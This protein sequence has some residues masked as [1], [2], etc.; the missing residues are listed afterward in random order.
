MIMKRDLRASSQHEQTEAEPVTFKYITRADP[1]WLELDTLRIEPKVIQLQLV[2][3][4][5]S[6]H[7]HISVTVSVCNQPKRCNHT[8]YHICMKD[9]QEMN[10]DV[11]VQGKRRRKK[12]EAKVRW[13]T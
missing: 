11:S 3:Q 2:H 10:A 5:L 7:H 1:P 12:E 8:G 9:H 4:T 13:G 6:H